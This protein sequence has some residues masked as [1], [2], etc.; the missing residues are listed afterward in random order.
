VKT[1]EELQWHR[2]YNDHMGCVKGCPDYLG[3]ASLRQIVKT[4]QEESDDGLDETHTT[5]AFGLAAG[6]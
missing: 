5:G 4:L 3:I 6:A 1:L 2:H